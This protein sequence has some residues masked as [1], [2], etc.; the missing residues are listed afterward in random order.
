MQTEGSWEVSLSFPDYQI[1]FVFVVSLLVP[2]NGQGGVIVHLV[3]KTR[4][5]TVTDFCLIGGGECYSLV[6]EKIGRMIT[7]QMDCVG[8]ND[9]P[10]TPPGG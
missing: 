3:R 8:Q 6:Q 4:V 2:K 7:A 9:H 10:T 5:L 1:T